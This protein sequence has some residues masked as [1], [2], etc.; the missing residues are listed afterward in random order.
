MNLT[1]QFNNL[2]GTKVT[3]QTLEKLLVKSKQ[4]NHTEIYDQINSLLVNYKHKAF[5]ITINN[6]PEKSGLNASENNDA[7][8]PKYSQ[9]KNKPKEAIKFLLK[10]KKGDCSN[11]LY[12]KDIGFIDILWGQNDNKNKGFGLKH[13]YEK[14]GKEIEQLGFKIEDFLPIIVK[15]GNFKISEKDN[16]KIILEGQMFRIIIIKK[17]NKTFL[18]SAFDL[19][20]LW[21]KEK[22]KGLNGTYEGICFKKLLEK[23][24]SDDGVSFIM[25]P[26]YS[27]TNNLVKSVK[28]KMVKTPQVVKTL[29]AI[30]GLKPL[31]KNKDTKNNT[32]KTNS[33]K[34]GLNATAVKSKVTVTA[35][36]KVTQVKPVKTVPDLNK[37][38]TAYNQQNDVKVINDY[39]KITGD[40]KKLLGNIEIKPVHSLAV[41]LDSGEGG[42]KTHTVF[43]WANDFCNAG[44]KPII[45]SLEEHKTSSLSIDKAKKYFKGDNI[46]KIAVE[47]ENDG[48]TPKETYDRLQESCKDFDIII[49]DSWAKIVEMYSKAQF[50]L[51]FRKKFNGKLFIVIFQR[52]STGAMRGGAKSGFDGDI[53]LKGFVDRDNFKNNYVFNHKNRYNNYSPISDLKYSPALQKL[54]PVIKKNN[55][56]EKISKPKVTKKVSFKVIN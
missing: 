48:E 8:F 41:T 27:K 10:V 17:P 46:K 53:I 55:T 47:S 45:W 54:L 9:F 24:K 52:T 7:W 30:G 32:I 56:I 3:R 49:I 50:D 2:N 26:L 11:A 40:L 5:V 35:T 33:G 13:I 28:S 4:E 22:S 38:S 1:T 39:F 44:Y 12:R 42:G 19:R 31:S 18:L 23:N 6:L 14:H 43:Q 21:K 20:P 37:Y 15:Y 51:D 25:P 29:P 16:E 36:K 34:K